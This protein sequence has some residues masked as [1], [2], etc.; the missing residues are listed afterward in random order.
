MNKTVNGVFSAI[1]RAEKG[2]LELLM[3][4]RAD[5]RG[6]NLPGG[7]VEK[8]ETHEQ[9]L[10]REVREETGFDIEIAYQIGQDFPMKKFGKIVDTARIYMVK[11][12]GGELKPTQES[13]GFQWISKKDLP[14]ADIV[15]RP[16]PGFP[17]GRTYAMA[18]MA[19]LQ[20]RPFLKDYLVVM[21]ED[22]KKLHIHHWVAETVHVCAGSLYCAGETCG[23]GIN[24]KRVRCLKCEKVLA[25]WEYYTP[26]KGVIKRLA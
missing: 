19:L 13:V 22:G 6:L 25:E 24:T 23:D 15:Q 9:A 26:D 1:M 2:Q 14:V 20:K 10:I 12:T 18:E 4:I 7:R 5:G 11:V 21:G 16:C 8:G 17:K 3:P